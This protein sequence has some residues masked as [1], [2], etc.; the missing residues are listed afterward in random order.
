MKIAK[1]R[2]LIPV[3]AAATAL[4][5]VSQSARADILT[6]GVTLNGANEAPP[7]ASLGVGTATVTIDTVL[8]TMRVETSFSGLTGNTTASHIHCCTTVAGANTAAVA[9]MTP[10][11]DVFPLGVTSGSMD[12]TYDMS[13]AGS[14]R[15]GYIT[16]NGGTPLSAFTALLDGID[17]GK[18]YLN[19]HS[20][21]APGGE[22]RGFL[23]AVPL[24]DS[25]PLLFSGLLALGWFGMR[26][27]AFS[28]GRAA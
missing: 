9:T 26:R 23:T 15:A 5:A 2:T 19:I 10:S 12:K 17:T 18:A 28:A 4:M 14:W 22:I 1:I 7:N 8:N 24:P 25:L 21:F 16:D 3:L 20:T 11:F 6:Y 13:Q 27:G